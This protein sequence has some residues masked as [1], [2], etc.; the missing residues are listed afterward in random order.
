[1]VVVQVPVNRF[2]SSPLRVAVKVNSKFTVG[3]RVDEDS[4]IEYM[5]FVTEKL[6]DVPLV[7]LGELAVTVNV[8]VDSILRFVI[9][10]MPEAVFPEVV[11]V[12]EPLDK[13]KVIE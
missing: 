7:R 2:P 12:H 9:V 4:S 5:R 1:M 3:V 10:S 8:P 13:D 6:E 11:P